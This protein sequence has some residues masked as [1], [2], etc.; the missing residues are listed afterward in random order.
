MGAREFRERMRA[1]EAAEKAKKDLEK[2]DAKTIQKLA[3]DQKA[4]KLL[5]DAIDTECKV[6]SGLPEG[7]AR[8]EKKQQLLKTYLP[9]IDKY[10]EAGEI[11]KNRAMTQVLIWLFDVGDIENAMRIANAAVDQDQPMPERFTRGVKVFVADAF[12]EWV[13]VQE[14]KGGSIQPYFNEMFAKVYCWPVHDSIK[15]KYLKQAATEAEKDGKPEDA[16][17]LLNQAEKLDPVGAKVKTR[18]DKLVKLIEK[19][20]EEELPPAGGGDGKFE[21]SETSGAS[22]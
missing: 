2:Q 7:R 21:K 19:K 12:L 17:E 9:V 8:V 3:E 5:L 14:A 18:K 6:I 13:K 15:I 1:K 16:L 22:D 20:E 11:Y 4:H 10:L